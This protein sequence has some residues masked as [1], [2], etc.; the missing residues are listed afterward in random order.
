MTNNF[1]ILIVEDE[2]IIAADISMILSN[3]GYEITGIT[4][5][6]EDA[7]KS[8]EATKPDLVL[9]DVA[10]KGA[11]DGVDTA[12]MINSVH[13]IPV[14]F[15]TSNADDTTFNRA[16][17]A[18]PF[19]FISKPFRQNDLQRAIELLIERISEKL[20]SQESTEG[21]NTTKEAYLL[22]DR[23]FIRYKEKMLGIFLHEIQYLEADRSYSKLITDQAEYLLTMP[24]GAFEEKLQSPEFLRIHRSYIININKIKSTS[25]NFS[26]VQLGKSTLPVSK[27]FQDSLANKLRVI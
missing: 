3:L 13:K 4:P 19:A 24:L 25:D 23:I 5:R 8:I 26:H 11:L 21:N 18:K 1:K 22:R 15:L 16:K 14:I 27:P 10:L 17:E 2:M 20:S 9:M 6:G 12:R 7:L